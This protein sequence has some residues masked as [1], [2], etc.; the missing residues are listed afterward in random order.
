[1]LSS[2]EGGREKPITTGFSELAYI[3]TWTLAARIELGDRPMAMPGELIDR[4]ELIVRKPMVIR[5]G[6]RFVIRQKGRTIISGVIT[7]V[8]GESGRDIRGFN[9]VPTRRMVVESNQSVVRRKRA[10]RSSKPP[11]A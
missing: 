11:A 1:M 9:Y 3:A 4:A 2:D 5:E 7:E 8:L 6:Q 10:Q